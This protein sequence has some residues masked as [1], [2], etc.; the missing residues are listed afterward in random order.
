M[1]PT[2]RRRH[3]HQRHQ[4]LRRRGIDAAVGVRTVVRSHVTAM[5]QVHDCTSWSARHTLAAGAATRAIPK[6]EPRATSAVGRSCSS[7]GP[8]GLRRAAIRAR[9]RGASCS[10]CAK[11]GCGSIVMGPGSRRRCRARTRSVVLASKRVRPR[12]TSSP[13][14]QRKVMRSATHGDALVEVGGAQHRLGQRRRYLRCAL[15]VLRPRPCS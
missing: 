4:R 15:H 7:S 12:F 8:S 10:S 2:D 5:P 11:S 14:D 13:C 6:A 1:R 3:P 9:R